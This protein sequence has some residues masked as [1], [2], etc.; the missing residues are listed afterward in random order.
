VTAEDMLDR[1]RALAEETRR[2][3]NPAYRNTVCEK[4]LGAA[5]GVAKPPGFGVAA[6]AKMLAAFPAELLRPKGE[7]A[8]NCF[9]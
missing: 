6:L 5:A 7:Q 9:G 1:V 2:F 3:H 8:K 4:A